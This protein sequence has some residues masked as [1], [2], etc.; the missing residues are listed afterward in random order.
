MSRQNYEICKIGQMP[1][2]TML[3]NFQFLLKHAGP[4]FEEMVKNRRISFN[5]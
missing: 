1:A 3:A 2:A 4:E 5:N